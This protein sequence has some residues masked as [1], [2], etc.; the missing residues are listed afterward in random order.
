MNDQKINGIY[1]TPSTLS[2]FLINESITVKNQIVLDPCYGGGSLIESAIS[3]LEML[4]CENPEKQIFGIDI[5]PTYNNKNMDNQL[6]FEDYFSIEPSS[7]QTKFDVIIM[8]P[9]FIRKKNIPADIYERIINLKTINKW[10]IPP[11]SDMWLFFILHSLSFMKKGG[12]VSAILP[13]PFLTSQYGKLIRNIIINNF[14]K[15][16]IHIFRNRFFN[17]IKQRIV[18]L[19]AYNYKKNKTRGN[20]EI[21]IYNNVN[22]LSKI[23]NLSNKQWQ[24]NPLIFPKPTKIKEIIKKCIDF[25]PLFKDL[26]ITSG[27]VTGANDYFIIE[28]SKNHGIPKK[29]LKKIITSSNILNNLTYKNNTQYE[30]ICIPKTYDNSNDV[31]N[32]LIQEGERRNIHN[33]KYIQGRDPWYSIS[34]GNKP[35]G[36]FHYITNRIP[37]I[38]RNNTRCLNTNSIHSVYFTNPLTL[39]EI[40]WIQLSLFTSH[41][42]IYIEE[43]SKKYESK[44]LKVEPSITDHI[45]IYSALDEKVPKDLIKEIDLLL[46]QN[47]REEVMAIADD[48]ILTRMLNKSDIK[49]LNDYYNYLKKFRSDFVI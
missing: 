12:T 29:F 39:H 3:K 18:V 10:D 33:R 44:T 23:Y 40:H 38:V 46:S 35:D 14:D 41:S 2:K 11:R 17:G 48:L 34:Y 25:N 9:P 20:V 47:R 42:Q 8:N 30:L 1:Y 5:Y 26:N 28:K 27:V 7:F 24:N 22:D 31:I 6:I 32:E 19:S 45:P 36:F 43:Y 21:L 16:K 49:T 13:W 37:Y 15:I 4:G